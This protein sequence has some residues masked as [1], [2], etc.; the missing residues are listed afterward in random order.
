MND[1]FVEERK[2]SD[3]SKH[4]DMFTARDQRLMDE[5]L[6][7]QAPPLDVRTI[8]RGSARNCPRKQEWG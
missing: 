6:L 4:V 8:F 5:E 1:D 3:K 2:L 7:I